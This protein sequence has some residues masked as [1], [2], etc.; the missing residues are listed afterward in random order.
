MTYL[1]IFTLK[2]EKAFVIFE[3]STLK[4]KQMPK[5]IQNTNFLKSV[6]KIPIFG[7]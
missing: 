5:F 7:F 2:I 1:G 3:I 6:P 4:Y